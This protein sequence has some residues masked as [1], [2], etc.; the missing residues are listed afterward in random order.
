M[1]QSGCE[2]NWLRNFRIS[3]D[4]TRGH[5]APHYRMLSLEIETDK[6]G[7]VGEWAVL[8]GHLPGLPPQKIGILLREV[9]QDDLHVRVRP[10]WWRGL[11]DEEESEIWSEFSEHLTQR[12]QEIGAAQVLDWL[13]NTASHAIQISPRQEIRLTQAE[14]TLDTLYREQ[15]ESLDVRLHLGRPERKGSLICLPTS[16]TRA[17]SRNGNRYFQFDSRW[18]QAAVAV[19][20]LGVALGGIR[21]YHSAPKQK[22]KGHE[23]MAPPSL[24]GLGYRPVL[25]NLDSGAELYRA[26]RHH[27]K[28]GHRISS[29]TGLRFRMEP[30]FPQPRLLEAAYSAPPNV[31]VEPDVN[32]ALPVPLSTPEAPRFRTRH[33]RFVRAL[34]ALATPFRLMFVS[35]HTAE[36]LLFGTYAD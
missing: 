23:P 10:D 15:V 22:S 36:G 24:A 27:R 35:K 21:M 18:G 31:E 25:F 3:S 9:S 13:E 7:K 26:T 2:Q 33:N 19:L 29:K 8:E 32:D 4:K 5:L 11:L 16:E 12:A 34:A 30:R 17:R 20:L 1:G 28:K 6:T 14:V